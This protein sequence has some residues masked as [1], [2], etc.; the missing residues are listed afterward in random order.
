MAPSDSW[1]AI[2]SRTAHGTERSL[3]SRTPTSEREERCTT[4]GSSP[5]AEPAPRSRY[6]RARRHGP[7][8]EAQPP[9][10]RER[11]GSPRRA[12]C[13]AAATP[14]FG[15][16]FR[17]ESAW[18][19]CWGSETCTELEPELVGSQRRLSGPPAVPRGP[20]TVSHQS[21]RSVHLGMGRSER[22][23]CSRIDSTPPGRS[24]V[25]GRTPADSPPSPP[26]K[27][28]KGVTPAHSQCHDTRP[29]A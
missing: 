4:P 21:G 24:V 11:G 10:Q 19:G 26:A 18:N 13:P 6:S 3:S 22:S 25:R 9:P 7:A 16:E 17:V 29:A 12:M 1:A 23:P 8:E 5:R 27:E 15:V 2:P 14:Y 28:S 20:F